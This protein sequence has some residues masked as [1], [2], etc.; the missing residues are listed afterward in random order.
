MLDF[1]LF[2]R[3]PFLALVHVIK[4]QLTIIFQSNFCSEN[5]ILAEAMVCLHCIK[6]IFTR[7]AQVKA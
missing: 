3:G 6:E 4:M 7:E 5:G 2:S 1:R